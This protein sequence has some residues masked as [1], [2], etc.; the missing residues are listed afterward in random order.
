[1]VSPKLLYIVTNLLLLKL[2]NWALPVT[3]TWILKP[4]LLGSIIFI[5]ILAQTISGGREYTKPAQKNSQKS[6]LTWLWMN[7]MWTER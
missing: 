1:M 5:I 7:W 4:K 6:Q 3:L 2:T